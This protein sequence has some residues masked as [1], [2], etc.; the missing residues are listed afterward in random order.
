M[1]SIFSGNLYNNYVKD[2]NTAR[3]QRFDVN[4]F[5]ASIPAL[6]EQSRREQELR[7]GLEYH[8]A[9]MA[10]LQTKL[11]ELTEKL[12]NLYR[13]F[14][15]SQVMFQRV[16]PSNKY[17][18]TSDM[19]NRLRNATDET[20]PFN[21]GHPAGVNGLLPYD[22]PERIRNYTY[23][24]FFGS[25][26]IDES[27]V[28][29]NRT[30]WREPNIVLEDAYTENGAFWST[31][32]YLW[33]WDLDR[34]N[35]T[36]VTTN[37]DEPL[38]GNTHLRLNNTGGLGPGT[39]ITIGGTEYTVSN[40]VT[41]E[42]KNGNTVTDVLIPQIISLPDVGTTVTWAAGSAEVQT[43]T[44]RE[45]Y[46]NLQINTTALQPNKEQHPPVRTGDRIPIVN[47]NDPRVPPPAVNYPFLAIDGIRPGG[48]DFSHAQNTEGRNEVGQDS[49]N[50]GWEFDDLPL[51]LEV[52]GTRQDANGNIVA[53]GY[54]VVY[55]IPRTHPQYARYRHLDGTEPMIIDAPTAMVKNRIHQNSFDYSG[56]I[57]LGDGSF[58]A[59]Y[60]TILSP[61]PGRTNAGHPSGTNVSPYPVDFRNEYLHA[62]NYAQ[63]SSGN[64][65]Q[66]PATST[67]RTYIELSSCSPFSLGA[68][69]HVSFNYDYTVTQNA[70]S[71]FYKSPSD[72]G[73]VP[74]T[75]GNGFLAHT[76]SG[77]SVSNPYRGSVGGSGPFEPP[78]P[79]AAVG[80]TWPGGPNAFEGY[81]INRDFIQPGV[82]LPE[83]AG[84]FGVILGAVNTA[85]DP[86]SDP[87][88]DPFHWGA[89]IVSPGIAS[90]IEPTNTG[91]GGNGLGPLRVNSVAALNLGGLPANITVNG[92][93]YTVTSI[94][95]NTI[96]TSTPISAA[97]L[98]PGNTVVGT[99][100][101]SSTGVAVGNTGNGRP[102]ALIVGSPT[103]FGIGTFV[104]V[105]GFVGTYEVVGYTLADG[106]TPGTPPPGDPGGLILNPPLSGFPTSGNVFIPG[107]G[108]GAPVGGGSD[109]S[110][111]LVMS[112]E[113]ELGNPATLENDKLFLHVLFDGDIH[114]IDINIRD[115]KI[116]S[117]SFGNQGTWE[118]G[119]YN[120][121]NDTTLGNGPLDVT[122][123]N[124]L[125]V[126]NDVINKYQADKY[127]FTQFHNEYNNAA[128]NGDLK[129][130]VR[131]PYE[132]ALFN[133]GA[134]SVSG[135]SSYLY[136]E[137]WVDINN[138][139]INLGLDD[140]NNNTHQPDWAN[141]AG[142]STFQGGAVTAPA[143]DPNN[144]NFFLSDNVQGV[145]GFIAPVHPGDSCIQNTPGVIQT[146]LNA[147]VD[148]ALPY[149]THRYEDRSPNHLSADP[150]DP[151]RTSTPNAGVIAAAVPN[152]YVGTDGVNY[153]KA[154]PGIGD[155]VVDRIMG[156]D[157][158]DYRLTIPTTDLNV[159]QKE[160]DIVFNF[161]SL[162]TRNY[163][164]GIY[165]PFMEY[166]SVPG[167]QT[168]ARYR[169]DEA[170]NI[171]DRFG[172]G[173]YDPNDPVDAV[174]MQELYP[175]RELGSG[176][177]A[178]PLV[179]GQVSNFDGTYDNQGNYD[180]IDSGLL[181]HN[182]FSELGD[183]YNL[184]D[185][186]PDLKVDP[187]A[188]DP[189]ILR[190]EV[191]VGS[192]PTNF[193]Y[194]REGL[195]NSLDG[196]TGDLAAGDPN[197]PLQ[198]NFN[199]Q[200][201]LNF[202]GRSTNVDG[203][204]NSQH[205]IVYNTTM[206]TFSTVMLGYAEQD[207]RLNNQKATTTFA[208]WEGFPGM[209]APTAPAVRLIGTT[210]T[211]DN[212]LDALGLSYDKFAEMDNNSSITVDTRVDSSRQ[213]HLLIYEYAPDYS[214][215]PILRTANVIANP[216]G[217]GAAYGNGNGGSVWLS[218]VSFIQV[219]DVLTFDDGTGPRTK[220]VTERN[221]TGPGNAGSIRFE[222]NQPNP[223]DNVPVEGPITF[224]VFRK[225]E[226][227]MRAIPHAIPLPLDPTDDPFVFDSYNV[228]TTMA[229]TGSVYDPVSDTTIVHVDNAAAFL[230]SPIPPTMTIEIGAPPYYTGT[231][232]SSDV[233]I[234]TTPNIIRVPGNVSPLPVYDTP[235]VM[236]GPQFTVQ[237]ADG[238]APN[239][240]FTITYDDRG[241]NLPGN[242]ATV[243]LSPE[244][245]RAGRFLGDDARTVADTETAN[246]AP[247]Y[248][249][250]SPPG[251]VQPDA[252]I[253]LQ[254]VA[255]D[256][257]GNQQPRR[258]REIRVTIDSG[259]Q[260]I[261][262]PTG[263]IRQY[264]GTNA[265]SF[266]GDGTAANGTPDPNEPN[267]IDIN[268]AWPVALYD[269]F[270]DLLNPTST[271]DL[272]ISV[273][274]YQG[275]LDGA[276][277]TVIP[278]T[279][280]GE[281]EFAEGK[282]VTIN[283][284]TRI[285]DTVDT[286]ANTI[287]L[288]E[289]LTRPPRVG[290]RVNLGNS[291]GTEDLIMYLNR[292]QAMSTNAP[293]EIEMV[294]QD[295]EVTGYP[296]TTTLLAGTYIEQVGF[297]KPNPG[298][299][300]QD[301]D[302]D[303]LNHLVVNKGRSGGSGDNAFVQ[304]L[305]RIIDN[306]EYQELLRYDLMKNVFISHASN[307]P[308]NNVVASKL[309][310]TWD[311]NRRRTEIQLTSFTAFYKSA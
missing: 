248:F 109:E 141:G 285:I 120:P 146:A 6:S 98:A 121:L 154:N 117:Y 56:F 50:W 174:I 287:T 17:H 144:P 44:F 184:F 87:R 199:R 291:I 101:V 84:Q 163:S 158:I 60:S 151:M 88:Y 169:V 38:R 97:D 226:A 54:K 222:A 18:G 298:D 113:R 286:G 181:G 278:V 31:V 275:I 168:V 175:T 116:V 35:A 9:R 139:R 125:S 71:G 207:A 39:V 202:D 233:D 136:G 8:Q 155:G 224:G 66:N 251:Y 150:A 279:T 165:E 215:E 49:L 108:G 242:I 257:D 20:T 162:P 72:D 134:D 212:A 61:L 25:K 164:I 232:T 290:D 148:D 273:G 75:S 182:R 145:Y 259:E 153:T 191:Y 227:V 104:G 208:T 220:I 85:G 37:D 32:S 288:T 42:D 47:Q 51:A 128:E 176:T 103:T 193:Y 177:S 223:G 100:G 67:A 205:T 27:D 284:E 225:R 45:T 297:R 142:E 40:L 23:N 90:A 309:M 91:N 132:Y 126:Q 276:T 70:V 255:Q 267:G 210:G 303:A 280:V 268:E 138:R 261:L 188:G 52:T 189:N 229:R 187:F 55:D 299:A 34:I 289:P 236:R 204:F 119:L 266:N 281:F 29:L 16:G 30:F 219:G 36:Y 311:R 252:Q 1:T 123:D 140:Y 307:D 105:D 300:P 96:F 112:Q 283:G 26:A 15:D 272:G 157:D 310:L 107:T 81:P 111:R 137:T 63:D 159:L 186:V 308:Y 214:Q 206:P 302:Y 156:G 53:S 115:F 221:L 201:A 211:V 274:Y 241:T 238:D 244:M 166:R 295:Y 65:N 260:I 250:G 203:Q 217:T 185:Y 62:G 172:E 263:A 99:D 170:G 7:E 183:D 213:G 64:W 249:A 86:L 122:G 293:I 118:N 80:A 102:S 264:Y 247:E 178:V 106:T 21:T 2:Q 306:P 3:L 192:L 167:Y 58:N 147:T 196:P 77:S 59:S 179:N 5:N 292:S 271:D 133:I 92:N 161:G 12:N 130:I 239:S 243:E 41:Y 68:N 254:L 69:T 235:V 83:T 82:S 301:A 269:K 305:K 234:T 93:P 73:A 149:T 296:P 135:E 218:D 230:T 197:G 131:S 127:N 24:P 43:G 265:A 237:V 46:N 10:D 190:G 152:Y 89:G 48:A 245:D 231:I 282:E 246:V 258:L 28:T 294:W 256:K 79:Y 19:T 95:G 14:I 114:G 94:V 76:W 124:S 304:E 262:G 194:Y 4:R 129:D 277:T 173:Y 180:P 195:D 253:N 33:G 200:A 270:N 228:K 57:E 78:P 160:N 209:G 240:Q 143:T 13:Q 74:G 110:L 171:Y 11:N 22:S 198:N 216:T